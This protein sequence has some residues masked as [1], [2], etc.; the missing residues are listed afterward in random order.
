MLSIVTGGQVGEI[1]VTATSGR[2]LNADELTQMALA[3]II[4]VG[5]D[6]PPAIRDQA[7]AYKLRISQVLRHYIGQ[8]Q[9]SQN[10]TIYNVLMQAGEID[11]A[12]IVR[13][14]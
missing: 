9:A 7:E 3:K 5:P 1:A 13:K 12:E 6:V 2:G 8:A 14:L 10:T 4:F 11:A